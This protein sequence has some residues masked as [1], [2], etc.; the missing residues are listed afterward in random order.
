MG[1]DEILAHLPQPFLQ[2][3]V[4]RMHTREHLARN[5][6]EVFAGRAGGADI[7][8]DSR[9]PAGRV[10]IDGKPGTCQVTG[11][12]TACPE[13]LVLQN[14]QQGEGLASERTHRAVYEA[15][16]GCHNQGATMPL[17]SEP[18]VPPSTW[19]IDPSA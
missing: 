2:A 19:W 10:G 11:W 9:V 4:A 1:R 3:R 12:A 15:S 16:L 17:S 6:T 7:M 18:K 8:R 13:G 5:R 14:G